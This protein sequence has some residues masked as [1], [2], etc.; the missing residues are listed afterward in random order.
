MEAKQITM[1]QRNLSTVSE[2]NEMKPNL[3]D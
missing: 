3:V 2:P 1:T